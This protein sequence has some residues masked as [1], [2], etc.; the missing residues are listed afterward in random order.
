MRT[1]GGGAHWTYSVPRCNMTEKLKLIAS[2]S[3]VWSLALIIQGSAVYLNYLWDRLSE[4][5]DP[6]VPAKC[7]EPV[8]FIVLI[9]ARYMH[10]TRQHC[11]P[12]PTTASNM[13]QISILLSS[14]T[15]NILKWTIVKK[16][17]PRN[18]YPPRT[19]QGWKLQLWTRF[20]FSYKKSAIL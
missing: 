19:I 5:L 11:L 3:F 12:P 17:S 20:W 1:S 9:Q 16:E 14:F 10:T 6:H 7:Y 2:M 13:I 8:I 18:S 15:K 4:R